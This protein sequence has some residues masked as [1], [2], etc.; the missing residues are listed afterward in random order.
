MKYPKHEKHESYVEWWGGQYDPE[1]IG[2]DE[3][4]QVLQEIDQ[5]DWWWE[6][7]LIS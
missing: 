3:I 5:I 4:N 2:L 1:A 7:F 6:D